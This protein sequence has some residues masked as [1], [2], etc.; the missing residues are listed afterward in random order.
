[1]MIMK[2]IGIMDDINFNAEELEYFMGLIED[3]QQSTLN[4]LKENKR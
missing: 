4:L 1:M 2:M 3:C